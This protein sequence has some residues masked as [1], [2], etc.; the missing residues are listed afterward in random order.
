MREDYEHL[1]SQVVLI[2]TVVIFDCEDWYVKCIS[3]KR[4]KL[5]LM[6]C[7]ITRNLWCVHWKSSSPL[8]LEVALDEVMGEDTFIQAISGIPTSI[9]RES[10][11]AAASPDVMG[12]SSSSGT[13]RLD[14][15]DSFRAL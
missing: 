15:A 12:E 4:S 2:V 9:K 7:F 5:L 13:A 11:Q 6:F 1:S 10:S 14:K 8:R 3:R